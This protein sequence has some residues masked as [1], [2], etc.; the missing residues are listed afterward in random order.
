MGDG[1][2]LF[3]LI[4]NELNP[5][6]ASFVST[7]MDS[8]SGKEHTIAASIMANLYRRPS[9]SEFGLTNGLENL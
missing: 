5:D 9:L 6:K 1:L 4:F 8:S 7:L 2:L 3:D